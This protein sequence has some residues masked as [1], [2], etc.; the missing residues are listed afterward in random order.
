MGSQKEAQQI[1]IGLTDKQIDVGLSAEELELVHEG[2]VLVNA[3]KAFS[4]KQAMRSHW[5]AALWSFALSWALVMEGFDTQLVSDA[6]LQCIGRLSAAFWLL[7]PSLLFESIRRRRQRRRGQASL[8]QIP[9]DDGK[10]RY[11]W[12]FH[13]AL[14]RGLRHC[15]MG[16]PAHVHFWNGPNDRY[17]VPLCLLSIPRNAHCLANSGQRSLGNFP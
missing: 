12:K 2:L 5:R 1:H 17:G 11:H 6:S 14:V 16:I 10:H 7:W 13:R 4:F 3:E 8:C 9:G 15:S